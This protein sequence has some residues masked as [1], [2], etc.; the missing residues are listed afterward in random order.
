[1]TAGDESAAMTVGDELRHRF[2]GESV[3]RALDL[4]GEKWTLLILRE[5]FFGVRRYGQLA[6]N[7]A[8]P[9]PTLSAR[10]RTLVEA[11]LLDRVR[12]ATDPDRHEYRLTR[13][14][15]DLYPAIVVLMRWG[16]S[17]LAG[18]A[19]PPIVLRHH[20]CG[21]PAEAFLACRHCGEEITA[22]NVTPEPGPGFAT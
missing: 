14:G 4:V 19:G 1:M 18:P 6:R 3:G 22:H 7:L 16:D 17:Y 9:R 8:I 13:A 21:E 11:G 12:Y 5:A 2:D 20:S 15:Q 10:L